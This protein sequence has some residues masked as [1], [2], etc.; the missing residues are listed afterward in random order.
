MFEQTS[1][2]PKNV[3]DDGTRSVIMS[4]ALEQL[5]GKLTLLSEDKNKGISDLMIATLKEC[6]KSSVTTDMLR[7]AADNIDDETVKTKL[8]EAALIFDSF[9]AI[10]SQ[11]Y[12]D[13][14][15]DLDRVHNILLENNDIFNGYTFFADSFS[16]FTAQ[17]LKLIRLLMGRCNETYIALTLDPEQTGEE[18]VFATCNDTYKRLKA[19]ANKD[20]INIKAPVKLTECTRFNNNELK[21]LEAF[22]FRNRKPGAPY[23]ERPKMSAFIRLPTLTTSAST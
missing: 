16:G 21:T 6:K 5:S 18:E 11:S 15:D 19:I 22:A 9:D 17:Q 12:I 7:D 4:L 3:I 14:L 13:P 2:L 20:F 1:H 10:V 8:N 23:P